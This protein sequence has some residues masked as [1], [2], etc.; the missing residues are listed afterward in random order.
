MECPKCGS[1]LKKIRVDVHGA[2]TKV[3]SY[4]CRK[5]SYFSF[6]PDTSEK[7]I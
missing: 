6:D 7:A 2:K 5:C 1:D 4:Q 3:L